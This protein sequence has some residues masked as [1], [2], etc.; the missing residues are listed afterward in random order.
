MKIKKSEMKSGKVGGG[1]ENLFCYYLCQAR[2]Q[3][4]PHLH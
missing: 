4:D 3:K 2:G 1:T